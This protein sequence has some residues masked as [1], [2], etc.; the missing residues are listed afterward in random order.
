MKKLCRKLYLKWKAYPT[1]KIY[2]NIAF[3]GEAALAVCTMMG[4]WHGLMEAPSILQD[5]AIAFGC[6]MI[7]YACKSGFEHSKYATPRDTVL[8]AIK[9]N[10]VVVAAA[11]GL[12][13]GGGLTAAASGALS[14]AQM[15][16][17]QQAENQPQGGNINNNMA[18]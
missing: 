13:S 7:A 16:A 18:G 11:T 2:C 12:I 17:E 4:W 14:A 6:T 1:F 5:D 3:V 8:Q 10:P 15:Q 9:D